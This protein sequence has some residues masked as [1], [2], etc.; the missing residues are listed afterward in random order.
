MHPT[1]IQKKYIYHINFRK[2]Y[3]TSTH[4]WN[5]NNRSVYIPEFRSNNSSINLSTVSRYI[6]SISN[7][8]YPLIKSF[9]ITK[10][11][12]LKKKLVPFN[13]NFWHALLKVYMFWLLKNMDP[14]IKSLVITKYLVKKWFHFMEILTCI[15]NRLMP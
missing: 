15:V 6:Y 5:Y 8:I 14:I 3:Q 4:P 11:H 1:H 13:G 9:I 7:Q 12:Y 10:Y 2:N